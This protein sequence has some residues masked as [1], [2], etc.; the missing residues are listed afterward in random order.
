[1]TAGALPCDTLSNS[2]TKTSPSQFD[3]MYIMGRFVAAGYTEKEGGRFAAKLRRSAGGCLEWTGARNSKGYGCLVLRNEP[4]LA[5]RL[6]HVVFIGPIPEG[7]EVDH[8]RDSG[9]TSILC[10]EPTHL[11]SVT[12]RANVLRAV[13]YRPA[14]RGPYRRRTQSAAS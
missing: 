14:H 9:C 12:K 1:M 8:V 5:H 4:W 3:I 6:A 2:T 7:H 10:T 11:E 13:P